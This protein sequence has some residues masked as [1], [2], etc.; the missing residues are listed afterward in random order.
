MNRTTIITTLCLLTAYKMQAQAQLIIPAGNTMSI[1]DMA[2]TDDGRYLM[3]SAGGFNLFEHSTGKQIYSV[4]MRGANFHAAPDKLR[5]V[6][7]TAAQIAVTEIATGRM[8]TTIDE[9]VEYCRFTNDGAIL[10][11]RAGEVLLFDADN[12]RLLKTIKIDGFCPAFS[13]EKALVAHT[14]NKKLDLLAYPGKTNAVAGAEWTSVKKYM[15]VYEFVQAAFSRDGSLLVTAPRSEATAATRVVCLETTGKQRF[16]FHLPT[17]TGIGVAVKITDLFFTK[18][19]KHLVCIGEG[20]FT[21]DAVTGKNTYTYRPETP[22]EQ[23]VEGPG[24]ELV[25]GL[26]YIQAI[27]RVRLNSDVELARYGRPIVPESSEEI[28]MDTKQ[29]LMAW[30]VGL[31][32]RI[33]LYSLNPFRLTGVVEETYLNNTSNKADMC[34]HPTKPLLLLNGYKSVK[35]V[36]ATAAKTLVIIP[37]ECATDVVWLP[38]DRF[39]VLA[40]KVANDLAQKGT[41]T[42][43]IYDLTGKPVGKPVA[44]AKTNFAYTALSTDGN[45]AVMAHETDNEIGVFDTRTGKKTLSIPVLSNATFS[46]A[47]IDGQA[48]YYCADHQFK[49]FDMQTKQNTVELPLIKPA[50]TVVGTG[51]IT[52]GSTPGTVFVFDDQKSYT[53]TFGEK[54]LR[55]FDDARAFSS[56]AL[57]NERVMVGNTLFDTKNKKELAQLVAFENDADW[58]VV[59]P[60]GR[61]DGSQVAFTLL[62]FKKDLQLFPLDVLFDQFYTPNLL[63]RLLAGENIPAPAVNINQIKAL[64]TAKIQPPVDAGQR[65][66]V[67]DDDDVR[68]FNTASERVIIEVQAT[69]IDDQIAGIQLYH[70]GKLMGGTTRNLVVEDDRLAAQKNRRVEVAL[71]PGENRFR[72][73]ASNSQKTESQPDEIRVVYTPADAAPKANAQPKLWV[74]AIG[75]NTYKNPKY[76]LNYAVPDAEAFKAALEQRAQGLFAKVETFFV[77]DADATRAGIVA[78]LDK[79]KANA[80]AQDVLVFYYAGHG[81]VDNTNQFYLVPHDVMQLYG[82][83]GALAQKGFSSDL[84]KNYSKDI[85]AQKQLFLLDACQSA[86]ALKSAATRGAAEE[87]ALRQLARSTGTHWITAAGSEQFAS[88]FAQLGHGTFTFALLEALAGKADAGNDGQV[89]VKELS[90]YLQ[91]IVPELTAKHKGTPQY[92]SSYGYGNDF[93]IG[94]VRK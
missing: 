63:T 36:D 41:A 50:S 14:L 28:A 5:V 59:T 54:M 78:A 29:G 53:Y 93:P 66:L 64:P 42:Y 47:H 55:P 26:Y 68:T 15:G 89:T 16:A 92:P 61:F 58:L 9:A 62:Y 35:I 70:N 88:E 21:F 13:P 23:A 18:D 79:V 72:A 71:V 40:F 82:D 12:Y 22:W 44:M 46:A 1:A 10:A 4:G 3:V 39:G 25:G 49:V 90:A 31:P 81:V 45:M 24:N 73:V 57:P 94:V 20:A 77:Q 43:T 33:Q 74:V 83:D 56:L 60:D 6:S 38:N 34:F 80:A 76:N 7:N 75:I 84:L 32:Y 86:G 27:S 52:P 2:L 85:A 30:S 51:R 37:T 19:N 48:V 67:V 65:N 17:Q 8:L 91:A 11:F 69:S 87:K